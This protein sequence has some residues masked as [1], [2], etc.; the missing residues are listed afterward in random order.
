MVNHVRYANINDSMVLGS[1][2]SQSFKQAYKDIIP[3]AILENFTA[4]KREKYIQKSIIDG[5]EEYILILKDNEPSGFMCIGK[6]RDEDL[7]SSFGEVWG[8]YLLPLF[9]NQGLGMELVNWGIQELRQ[10]GF[11]KIS[12]WVL[13]ENINARRF[14]EKL[15]FIHDGA[16]KEISIGKSLNEYRYIINIPK[17][18]TA[19]S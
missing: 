3:N 18:S 11:E 15:G 14:Y 8:I 9:W 10:R 7:D 2:H 19:I 1:I 4:E 12:L 16:V 6:C 13:E 17:E 5:T